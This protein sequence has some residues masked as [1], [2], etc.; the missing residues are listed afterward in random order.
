MVKTVQ[1]LLAEVGD[2][3]EIIGHAVGD[4][5]RTGEIIEVLG[6]PGHEHYRVR[7]EDGHESINFPGED[8]VI[9]RPKTRVPRKS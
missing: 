3:I 8:A 6:E 5:P 2:R 1:G 7:W 9:R 4:A